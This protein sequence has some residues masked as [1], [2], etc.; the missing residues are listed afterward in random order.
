[1]FVQHPWDC[2]CILFAV[3]DPGSCSDKSTRMKRL[4]RYG[5]HCLSDLPRS[6]QCIKLLIKYWLL[7]IPRALS[8]QPTLFRSIVDV[9]LR[10]IVY[11]R[12]AFI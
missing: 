3:F 5:Y 8:L 4:P 10:G 9:E 6:S 11:L 1:M 2:P 12:P 7:G